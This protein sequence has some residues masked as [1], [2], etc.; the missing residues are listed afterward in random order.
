[1]A[2]SIGYL[3]AASG[4]VVVGWLKDSTGSWTPALA[5]VA[6]VATVQATPARSGSPR[7]EGPSTDRRRPTRSD[8]AAGRAAS[9][10]AAHP[11]PAGDSIPT[12]STTRGE[13]TCWT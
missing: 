2:Q 12:E 7:A 10:D 9:V 3:V 13:L 4:P 11:A 8:P 5:F 1:M 6:A